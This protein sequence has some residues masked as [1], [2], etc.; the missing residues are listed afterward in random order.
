M[1][2]SG[3]PAA[4]LARLALDAP[5]S[6]SAMDG[7]RDRKLLKL[8]MEFKRFELMPVAPGSN[9]DSE[10]LLSESGNMVPDEGNPLSKFVLESLPC[11]ERADAP[12]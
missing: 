9:P 2:P 6:N 12:C 8:N 10:I 1:L 5:G 7:S 3:A 11:A 4:K